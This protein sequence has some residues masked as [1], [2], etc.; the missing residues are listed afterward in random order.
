MAGQAR[1]LRMTT[2][3]ELRDHHGLCYPA[4]LLLLRPIVAAAK[5]R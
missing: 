2:G 5:P 3:C 1:D 4:L